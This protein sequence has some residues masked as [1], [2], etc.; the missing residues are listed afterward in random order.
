MLSDG[1][2]SGLL[3]LNR[4]QSTPV[5]TTSDHPAL[6]FRKTRPRVARHCRG[7]HSAVKQC[8]RVR[9]RRACNLRLAAIVTER[10][11]RLR[12]RRERLVPLIVA[13]ALFMENMDCDRDR[14]LAAGDRSVTS[15][16]TRCRCGWRSP[17]T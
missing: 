9:F 4:S 2:R 8:L 13:T 11:D 10:S 1:G 15:E 7:R 17:P 16:P 3:H 12:M 6:P 14:D 5:H